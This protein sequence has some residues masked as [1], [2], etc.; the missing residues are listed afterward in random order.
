MTALKVSILLSTVAVLLGAASLLLSS[1]Q[2]PGEVEGLSGGG[3]MRADASTAEHLRGEVARLLERI[4]ALEADDPTPIE[5]PIRDRSGPG[6]VTEE[7]LEA[8]LAELFEAVLAR[9]PRMTEASSMSPLAF[10]AALEAAERR[11]SDRNS[12][13]QRG[14]GEE[15]LNTRT[16]KFQR[17]LGL[18][19]MQAMQLLVA[20]DKHGERNTE[21]MKLHE[22]EHPGGSW[23]V[24]PGQPLR[25]VMRGNREALITELSLFLDEEQCRYVADQVAPK[26]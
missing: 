7:Q 6:W 12:D 26:I 17:E 13:G 23:S 10:D 25:E 18:E 16:L 20:L 4:E 2:A 24:S 14:L 5:A 11:E 19:H 15:S 1:P 22:A 21:V 8:R 9:G 3:A